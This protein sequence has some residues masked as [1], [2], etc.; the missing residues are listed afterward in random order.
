MAKGNS[1]GSVCRYLS[2]RVIRFNILGFLLYYIIDRIKYRIG[3]YM[4]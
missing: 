1:L 3:A 4:I 2:V